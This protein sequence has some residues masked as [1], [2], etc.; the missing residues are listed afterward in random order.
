MVDT[1]DAALPPAQAQVIH[2][3]LMN[4]I[5]DADQSHLTIQAGEGQW[6]PFVSGVSIKVLRKEAGV[7]SYL[8]RLEPGAVLAAHRHPQDEECIVLDGT[9]QVGTHIQMGPGSYHLAHRGALHA[10]ISTQTGATVFLRGAVPH[11]DHV[12]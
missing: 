2:S 5:A 10:A 9:L 3:R 4:R 12:L 11:A 8:L 6:Q 7:M 1:S